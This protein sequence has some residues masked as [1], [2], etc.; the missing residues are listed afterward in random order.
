MAGLAH[1]DCYFLSKYLCSGRD[2]VLLVALAQPLCSEY[3][4]Y[5]SYFPELMA[6]LECIHIIWV[7]VDQNGGG[8]VL[9]CGSDREH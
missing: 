9:V 3:W 7:P 4:R 5:F 1:C 2:S 8:G 6:G